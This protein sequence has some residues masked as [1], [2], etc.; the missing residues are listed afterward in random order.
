M[1]EQ[2]TAQISLG[3]GRERLTARAA[4]LFLWVALIPLLYVPQALIGVKEPGVLVVAILSTAAAVCALLLLRTRL[5]DRLADLLA[6][7]AWILLLLGIVLYV[8]ASI[9]HG[10]RTI[11]SFGDADQTALFNQMLWNTLHGHPFATSSETLDGSL[12][13]HFGIHFSPTLLLLLTVYALWPGPQVLVVVQALAVG[14]IPIPLYLLLRPRAGAAGAALLALAVLLV[15]PLLQLGGSDFREH[16]LLPVFLLTA[17]WALETRRPAFLWVSL[18]L[19]LG[20]RE[21]VGAVLVFLGLYALLTGRGRALWLPMAALGVAWLLVAVRIVMPHFW[22]P[23]LWSDPWRRFQDVS[24]FPG[25][26]PAEMAF[27]LLHRPGPLFHA[28]VNRSNVDYL[29]HAFR[30]LL[31][32]PP[33]GDAALL[34]AVPG[35]MTNLLSPLIY[36]KLPYAQYTLVPLVFAALATM[37][38]AVRVSSRALPERGAGAGLTAAIVV[39]CGLLPSQASPVSLE[40]PPHVP[41]DAAREV[42]R[43]LRPGE[44]VYAPPN[45]YVQ[46]GG[47]KIVG[48]SDQL[49]DRM[50]DPAIRIQYDRVILWPGDLPAET[51]LVRQMAADTRFRREPAPEPFLVYR[52]RS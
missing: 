13:S 41:L 39:G 29:Y 50:L 25:R 40:T 16:A 11:G 8:A 36:M 20:I 26:T 52:R 6:P 42:V 45:F 31:L 30:A 27:G 38:V 48:C 33:W 22:S 4:W 37:R 34:L 2:S 12:G 47:R 21:E 35:L 15:P 5:W 9:H 1:S 43:S 17:L 19:A 10:L 7:R 32:I 24:G 28:I 23:Q 14:L 3:R 51:T 44:A 49:H 46:I 18:L